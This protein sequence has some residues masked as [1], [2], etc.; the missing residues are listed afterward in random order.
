VVEIKG[1]RN[2]NQDDLAVKIFKALGHPVRFKI[3]KFLCDGPKCVCKLNEK[4]EYSQ[5]NLSQHLRI[6]KDAGL[7][8]SEKVGLEMH[9]RLYNDNIKNIVNYAE[10][11][12]LDYVNNIKETD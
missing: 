12:V 7:V 10:K 6:L 2:L 3:M 4:F 11:Y 8:K 9:Y 5:A 1:G